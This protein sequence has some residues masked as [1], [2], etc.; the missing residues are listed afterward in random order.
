[1]LVDSKTYSGPEALPLFQGM[2][3]ALMT[4]TRA[5]AF[6]PVLGAAFFLTE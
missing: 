1:M 4:S 5:N 2:E 3:G 6:G